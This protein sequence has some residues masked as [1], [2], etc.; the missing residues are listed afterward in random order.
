MPF[1]DNSAFKVE[2]K[3]KLDVKAKQDNEEGI[4]ITNKN[5]YFDDKLRKS[6]RHSSISCATSLKSNNQLRDGMSYLEL[7]KSLLSLIK[8][9][10]SPRE[11]SLHSLPPTP[12]LKDASLKTLIKRFPILPSM[13]ELAAQRKAYLKATQSKVHEV[14]KK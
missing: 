13:A 11:P 10:S 8:T 5:L 9:K 7:K 2:K 1:I 4:M 6:R 14:I 3:E 12:T